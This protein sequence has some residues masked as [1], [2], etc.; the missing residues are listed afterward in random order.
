M[1]KNLHPGH[2][3][4]EGA[5]MSGSQAQVEGSLGKVFVFRWT[6]V[7]EPPIHQNNKD[8]AYR[9]W[10]EAVTCQSEKVM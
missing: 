4:G 9:T 8:K 6:V 3:A 1:G 10:A 5:E 7:E 2:R